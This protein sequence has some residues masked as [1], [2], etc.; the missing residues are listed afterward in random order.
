MPLGDVLFGLAPIAAF[1]GSTIA[2]I[3]P[4]IEAGIVPTFRTG[5]LICGSKVE[6]REWSAASEAERLGLIQKKDG[7]S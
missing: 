4:L 5:N 2:E 7:A 3:V 6:L 1:L